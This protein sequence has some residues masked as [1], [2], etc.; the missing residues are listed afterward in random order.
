LTPVADRR[1][2]RR[3]G[4]ATIV[5]AVLARVGCA[6]QG[7]PLS[8]QGKPLS[9]YVRMTQVQPAYIGSGN[10]GSGVLLLYYQGSRNP[11]NVG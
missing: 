4:I 8:L 3:T 11:F 9:G 7:N 1:W 5:V 2:I 10:A 6:N